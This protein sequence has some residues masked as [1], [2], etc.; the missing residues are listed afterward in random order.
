MID[1]NRNQCGLTD[2]GF[3]SLLSGL[4]NGDQKAW[5]QAI[6]ALRPFLK[7]L[8]RGQL[9]KRIGHRADASDVVQDTLGEAARSLVQFQGASL[10]E[11]VAWLEEMLRNDACDAVRRHLLAEIRSV[12]R[13]S[14]CEPP[15]DAE[16]VVEE[17][18]IADQSTASQ[19][20]RRDE[21]ER[22]LH[23]ALS[24]L[25]ERQRIA[26]RMKHLEGKTLAEIG[27]VLGCNAGAAAAVVARGILAM[28][29]KLG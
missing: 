17:L 23:E 3:D 20:C 25:P 5:C 16:F 19:R 28:R 1:I 29:T 2:T 6:D 14:V 10:G 18:L 27:E 21:D 9:P 11:F 26:V 22:R 7:E 4:R 24:R 13:E 8:A 12:N 15:G